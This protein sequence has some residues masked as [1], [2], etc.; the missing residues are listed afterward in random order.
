MTPAEKM[1]PMTL[2]ID[3]SRQTKLKTVSKRT[4][5]SMSELVR[6]SI[7]ELIDRLGGDPEH[8]DQEALAAL[9]RQDDARA[10]QGESVGS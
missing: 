10:E 2:M 9:L 8:P 1:I 5:V 7:D 4:R 3:V 6:I